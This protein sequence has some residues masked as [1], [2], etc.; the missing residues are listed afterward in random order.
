V[1]MADVERIRAANPD[2]T[3]HVYP[4]G[5]HAFF[6]PAQ[7]SY[8]ADAASLAFARSIAFLDETFAPGA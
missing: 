6:N 3:V 1:P 8:H 2:V 7:P 4:G 5:Q